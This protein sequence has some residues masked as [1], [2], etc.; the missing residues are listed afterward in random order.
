MSIS[1]PAFDRVRDV[2]AQQAAGMT[3]TPSIF[4]ALLRELC[5]EMESLIV[6]IGVLRESANR[7]AKESRES[8]ESKASK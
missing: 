8:K 2:Y 3:I 1:T 5:A 4:P 6:E 7:L